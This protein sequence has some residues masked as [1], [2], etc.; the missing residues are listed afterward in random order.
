MSRKQ[1]QRFKAMAPAAAK[2]AEGRSGHRSSRTLRRANAMTN[3]ERRGPELARAR[4]LGNEEVLMAREHSRSA[5]P[6]FGI[7]H[8]EDAAIFRSL[9]TWLQNCG[10]DYKEREQIWDAFAAYNQQRPTGMPFNKQALQ[11][12]IENTFDEH[13]AEAVI[14]WHAM[15]AQCGPDCIPA[16]ARTSAGLR[17]DRFR[18][19]RALYGRARTP[20][21]SNR[22][23]R[24]RRRGVARPVVKRLLPIRHLELNRCGSSSAPRRR[25]RISLHR[26]SRSP[27]SPSLLRCRPRHL[28][29]APR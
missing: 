24:Q 3:L 26:I 12:H 29:S 2:S 23:G 8:G 1:A 4:S 14:G 13:A 9:M 15:V 17:R 10:Y 18:G 5:I 6:A 11:W 22:Q 19:L 28:A 25:A 16:P 21:C 7:P 20:A 27:G